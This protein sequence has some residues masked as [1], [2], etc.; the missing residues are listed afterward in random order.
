MQS[1]IALLLAF[2][3]STIA[4]PEPAIIDCP[5][6]G[7]AKGWKLGGAK[8][9][10]VGRAHDVRHQGPTP[11]GLQSFYRYTTSATLGDPILEVWKDKAVGKG[12]RKS[13]IKTLNNN[14]HQSFFFGVVYTEKDG[15]KVAW[16]YKNPNSEK[17]SIPFWWGLEP[18]QYLFQ[19]VK[20]I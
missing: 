13:Y 11:D 6:A 5:E 4:L 7:P 18:S 3:L 19:E 16:W 2:V 17:C 9:T 15:Q 1:F 10:A 14:R 20:A 8:A 12:P